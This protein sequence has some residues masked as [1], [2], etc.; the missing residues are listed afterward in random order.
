MEKALALKFPKT[1]VHMVIVTNVS[2][3]TLHSHTTGIGIFA[4]VGF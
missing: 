1:I 2:Y 3:R 4:I